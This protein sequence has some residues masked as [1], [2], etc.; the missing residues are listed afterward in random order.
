MHRPNV[1]RF[2]LLLVQ[3]LMQIKFNFNNFIF[4]GVCLPQLGKNGDVCSSDI[5]R[6]ITI[7]PLISKVFEHC[8]MA[9]FEHFLYSNKLQIGFKKKLSCGFPLFVL[10]EVSDYFTSRSSSIFI[11]AVDAS[12]AFDRVNHKTENSHTV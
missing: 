11:T 12:K 3:L 9:K 6:G 10:Q 1:S 7:S 2:F 8:L 4:Y 5:Y